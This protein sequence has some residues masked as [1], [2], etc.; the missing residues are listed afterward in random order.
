[1]EVGVVMKNRDPAFSSRVQLPFGN[2]VTLHALLKFSAFQFLH[3][4]KE[5]IIRNLF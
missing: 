4:K 5:V 3:L 2:C 1:M